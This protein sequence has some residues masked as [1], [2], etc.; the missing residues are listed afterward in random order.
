MN[1][2]YKIKAFFF[3]FNTLVLENESRHTTCI[4]SLGFCIRRVG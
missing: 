4:D 2:L 3:K 1:E